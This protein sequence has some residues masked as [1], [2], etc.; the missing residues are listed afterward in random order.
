LIVDLVMAFADPCSAMYCSARLRRRQGTLEEASRSRKSRKM[1]R[2]VP[3]RKA[4]GRYSVNWITFRRWIN[5]GK[6]TGYRL[7][8]RLIRVDF[9]EIDEFMKPMP[10]VSGGDHDDSA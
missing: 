5:E 8:D 3:I 1:A 7:G 2:Y 10:V 4:E 9:D 6:I